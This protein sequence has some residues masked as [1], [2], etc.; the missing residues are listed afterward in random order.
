MINIYS[1]DQDVDGWLDK[2]DVVEW[3][4]CMLKIKDDKFG[5]N[6]SM[7]NALLRLFDGLPH[8]IRIIEIRRILEKHFVLV[9]DG[10]G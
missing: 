8:N 5:T 4:E 1:D 7:I 10:T 9:D 2:Q 3:L 6:K